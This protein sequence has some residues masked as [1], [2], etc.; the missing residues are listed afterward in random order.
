MSEG[1]NE[2]GNEMFSYYDLNGK[3]I[4]ELVKMLPEHVF[5]FIAEER[6]ELLEGSPDKVIPCIHWEPREMYIDEWEFLECLDF[7]S[8]EEAWEH[9]DIQSFPD[10]WLV[11]E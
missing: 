11:I 2:R 5:D 1:Q 6:G 9:C 7:E 10:G 8:W 4:R 3:T